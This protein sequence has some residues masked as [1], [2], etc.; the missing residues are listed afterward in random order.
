[1]IFILSI[2]ST[3]IV[4]RFFR[5]DLCFTTVLFLYKISIEGSG[6][7]VIFIFLMSL[8]YLLS[9]NSSLMELKNNGSVFSPS[10]TINIV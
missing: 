1:M 6:A 10:Q 2:S 9:I 5:F 4:F 3:F 7:I 8:L